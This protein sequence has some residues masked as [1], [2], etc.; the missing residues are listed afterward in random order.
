MTFLQVRLSTFCSGKVAVT[1]LYQRHRI[2]FN[3]SQNAGS[4]DQPATGSGTELSFQT[5]SLN[6]SQVRHS[7]LAGF[8]AHT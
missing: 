2:I 3:A 4:K 5:D 1:I 8:S 6:D 7:A